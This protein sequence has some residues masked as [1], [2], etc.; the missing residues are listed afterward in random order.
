MST[1]D[2]SD[3]SQGS[4]ESAWAPLRNSLYRSLFIAQLIS[5]IGMWMATVGSQWFLVERSASP[6][7]IALVQTASMAPTLLL[8]LPGGVFA[9]S[10][11]RRRLLIGL[12]IY[13]A[14]MALL[15]AVLAWADV[16]TP[17]LLLAITFLL[18][19]GSALTA[20]AWQAIQPELVPREQI[21]AASSL[22]SIT[23][24]AARAI[25]PAIGGLLVAAGGPGA[26]FALNALSFV[27]LLWSLWRWKRPPDRRLFEREHLTT[28][29]WI[30][31]RY[32]VA[33]PTVK[34]ILVRSALF[35]FPGSALWSLLPLSARR[36][37]LGS[38]GYGVVLGVLGIG[39]LLGA[40]LMPTLRKLPPNVLLAGSA[41]V[42]G[43]A[44]AAAAS[45]PLWL[46]LI[47]LLF[48]GIAW[49]GTLTTLNA[50][51]QLTLP[52]WVR[53]RGMAVYLMVFMGSQ[54]IGALVWGA[55]A[56]KAGLSTALFVAAGCLL[57]AALSVV[58][59]PMDPMTGRL[60]RA[61]S[62]AW[63]TP[64]LIFEPRPDD[65]P[66]LVSISYQ[67][68][69]DHFARF[70]EAMR[71]VRRA[72]SRSGGRAWRL[73]RSGDR[74]GLLIEQFVV[75]SWVEYER[76]HAERWTGYDHD[77]VVTALSCTTDGQWHER[78][79]FAVDLHHPPHT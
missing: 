26:V 75:E 24:N 52:A 50:G 30:G 31:L 37:G 51:L 39:A 63:A 19:A 45:A 33:A 17:A 6:T 58:V 28:S 42:F 69:P 13:S 34:R 23:V 79:F 72:R 27:V 10:Y 53:A 16:L 11:D 14:V 12:S 62:T 54:S 46:A 76:Q 9:D 67:V 7:I 1:A 40:A 70:T 5:N 38:G 44:T 8:S 78:R 36:W 73:Y 35:A 22:G 57:L 49:I 61:L 47:I 65:G 4:A 59:L 64:T 41:L 21:S 25:G 2:S 18:G 71:V 15:L 60:D 29:M 56:S 48:A 74:E 3:A 20:P 32:V 77:A 43:A 55:L 68:R 66:V